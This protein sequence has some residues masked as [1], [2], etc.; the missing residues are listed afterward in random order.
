LIF[1]NASFIITTVLLRMSLTSEKP[2]SYFLIFIG[3]S[4]SIIAFYLINFRKR[5]E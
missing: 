5:P 1:R 2:M 3:F 4:F